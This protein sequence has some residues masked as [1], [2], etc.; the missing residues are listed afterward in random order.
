MRC[1]NGTMRMTGYII[2]TEFRI[3]LIKKSRGKVCSL[4]REK[5]KKPNGIQSESRG[6]EKLEIRNVVLTIPNSKQSLAI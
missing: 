6:K 4:D 1:T 3:G 5:N 2:L